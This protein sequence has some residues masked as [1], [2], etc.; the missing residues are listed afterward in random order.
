MTVTKS[1]TNGLGVCHGGILFAFAD[2]A[3]A[4]GSNEA[5]DATFSTNAT[6]EWVTP[7]R[8][9]ARLTATSTRVATRGKSAVHDITVT[10]EN[11]A[12]VALVRGQTLSTGGSVIDIS[13]AHAD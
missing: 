13:D 2:T 6:I 8:E 12:T 5:G 1:M 7:A 9:G 11:G 4:Y 10:D 3:M